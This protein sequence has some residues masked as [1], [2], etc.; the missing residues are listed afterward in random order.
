MKFNWWKKKNA[1]TEAIKD[2]NGV[3]MNSA[4]V[5]VDIGGEKV[6]V[7]D[8]E[9][10]KIAEEAE[11]AGKGSELEPMTMEDTFV[12]SN[13]KTYKVGDMVNAYTKRKNAADEAETKKKAEE[14]AEAK[15]KAEEEEAKKKENAEAEEK[16]KKEEEEKKAKEKEEAEKKENAKNKGQAFFKEL[17]NAGKTVNTEL[18][19][20]AQVKSRKERAADFAETVKN[21]KKE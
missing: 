7:A 19:P 1:K 8:L 6:S 16:K 2:Q 3:K 20:S 9:T 14:E 21:S 15:K 18:P 13:G 5:F 11:E 12:A 10:A 17:Q 4:D